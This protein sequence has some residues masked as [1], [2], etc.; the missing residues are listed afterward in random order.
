M[1]VVYV[2]S[3]AAEKEAKA[4]FAFPENIMMENAAAAL[5]CALD[6][7]ADGAEVFALI[8]CGGG[9][10]GGDGLALAR[11][12]CGRIDC[13]VCLLV[14]VKT[15]EAETQERM[16][17][18]AGVQF[19]DFSAA[20]FQS[21]SS[22]RCKRL[23]V[24]DCLFGT[25]FRGELPAEARSAFILINNA[26]CIKI[27]CDIPSGIDKNGNIA[28]KDDDGRPL[29]FCADC[30]VTMGALKTALYSD[31]AKDFTGRIR[32]APLGISEALFTQC[33]APDAYLLERTDMKLPERT[34]R[35]AHKGMFGHAVSV[36][37][38]KAGAGIIAAEAAL[39]FGAG[40]V[41]VVHSGLSKAGFQLPYS[42]MSEETIPPNANAVIFGSGLGRSG[43]AFHFAETQI[44]PFVS[45]MEKAACVIDADM[46][47]YPNLPALLSDLNAKPDARVILTP[48]PKEFSALLSL[49]GIT[50][51]DALSRRFD[52]A[53]A[54]AAR[55]PNLTL[56]AKGAV[57]Y[58]A[59][60]KNTFIVDFGTPALA[61]A[62]SGDALAGLC[63]ALLAQDY[64][65]EEAAKTAALAHGLAAQAQKASF[66][67]TPQS[68]IQNL[69]TLA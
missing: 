37:G 21:L 52:A 63:G 49:C 27:A 19:L 23:A 7:E 26:D 53:R 66:A 16:A 4:R 31:A 25:G 8:L 28:T 9:N 2:D 10:N 5:E 61:K 47:Y 65:A 42:L 38:E 36:L 41:S 43:D 39:H 6:E 3:S 32:V 59:R 1:K 50:D 14:D 48:H 60:G 33:A 54:F 22:D 64:G 55:F 62:G 67:L 29:A 58:I 15:A 57:T 13:A 44:I 34:K 69:E 17:R 11:R 40:L 51:F 24:V 18:R 56:I 45:G 12:I 46:F 20:L 35:S 68:L 30:T